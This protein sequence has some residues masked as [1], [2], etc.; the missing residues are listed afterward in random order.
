MT[1]AEIYDIVKDVPK[2]A[3]PNDDGMILVNYL[4]DHRISGTRCLWCFCDDLGRMCDETCSSRCVEFL[5]EA[6]MARWIG[7]YEVIAPD[8]HHRHFGHK[9]NEW[10]VVIKDGLFVCRS[11]TL[12]GALAAA[13]AVKG[14]A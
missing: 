2:E 4:E 5:F 8:Y 1:A 3:W 12:L 7:G 11:H 10:R 13:C 6:S 9:P 14:K